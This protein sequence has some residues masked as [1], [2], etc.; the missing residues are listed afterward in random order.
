MFR[1]LILR[2]GLIAGLLV[3]SPSARAGV[4]A[5]AKI[6]WGSLGVAL[7]N[8]ESNSNDP[9]R[10]SWDIGTETGSVGVNA[11]TAD[12]WDPQGDSAYAGDWTTLLSRSV[13]TVQSQADATRGESLL[14]ALASSQAGVSAAAPN[15]NSAN[16]TAYNFANFTVAGRGLALLSVNW[17]LSVR[18]EAGDY[19]DNSQA[20]ANLFA[21]YENAFANGEVSNRAWLDSGDLGDNDTN[22]TL[23][24][25]LANFSGITHGSLSASVMAS[26]FSTNVVPEPSTFIL[27]GLGMVMMAGLA[28]SRGRRRG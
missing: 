23:S 9:V 11:V 1:R 3:S 8:L 18:G 14:R 16:A 20:E 13:T 12:P 7:F 4:M 2:L 22:G 21:D 27:S 25:T 5:Q 19:V 24:L 15:Y 17:S 26:A 6:D 28:A 10:F